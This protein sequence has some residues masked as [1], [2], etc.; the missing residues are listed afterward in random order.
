MVEKVSQDPDTHAGYQVN[1]ADWLTARGFLVT[2]AEI[3]STS[4]VVEA[5]ATKTF[6]DRVGALAMVWVNGVPDATDVLVTCTIT[7][8]KPDPSAP[9]ITDQFS[10]IIRG[11]EK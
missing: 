8:P 5:P 3:V 4:F 9:N 2:G 7:M 6:E 10:F 11:L 1:W